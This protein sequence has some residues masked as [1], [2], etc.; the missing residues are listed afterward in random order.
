MA[1][2]DH[3]RI[4]RADRGRTVGG[5]DAPTNRRV[6]PPRPLSFGGPSAAAPARQPRAYAPPRLTSPRGTDWGSQGDQVLE[7]YAPKS[8]PRESG[9]WGLLWPPRGLAT[10][11]NAGA[12]GPVDGLEGSPGIAGQLQ[13]APN[14]PSD[15]CLLTT[16]HWRTP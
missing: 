7:A 13:R 1:N 11:P 4:V 16:G 5:I 8:R 9:D 3:S 15:I 6:S 2:P 10:A 14:L 12:V